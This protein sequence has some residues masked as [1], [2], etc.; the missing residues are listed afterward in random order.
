MIRTDCIE[1]RSELN[2]KKDILC[3]KGH[4]NLWNPTPVRLIRFTVTCFGRG[5]SRLARTFPS[6]T[7]N[8]VRESLCYF[9]RFKTF[10]LNF[11]QNF[12]F[13]LTFLRSLRLSFP[14]SPVRHGSMQLISDRA[15]AFI[16]QNFQKVILK[17]NYPNEISKKW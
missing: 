15:S 3:E 6:I 10:K 14:S 1:S 12:I 5:A 11:C 8:L 9:L 16:R 17:K 2:P 13:F 7:E 4:T